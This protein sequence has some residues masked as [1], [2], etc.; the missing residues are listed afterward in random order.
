LDKGHYV[1]RYIYNNE[2]I[3]IGRTIDIHRRISE[4]KNEEKFQEFCIENDI[5]Y[6]DLLVEYISLSNSTEESIVEK[7]LINH[8]KPL[9]NSSDNHKSISEYI[10]FSIDNKWEKYEYHPFTK[11]KVPLII[12]SIT[13][14][15]KFERM[16]CDWNN[17]NELVKILNN[18][19]LDDNRD[20]IMVSSINCLLLYLRYKSSV[21]CKSFAKYSIKKKNGNVKLDRKIC[22]MVKFTPLF[23]LSMNQIRDNILRYTGY[24][25]SFSGEKTYESLFLNNQLEKLFPEMKCEI[26]VGEDKF[27][28]LI[29]EL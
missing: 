21:T 6:K 15:N 13:S 4:H 20:E 28:E 18:I 5:E 26:N 29:K 16:I 3:Y 1:Y 25:N 17:I 7:M 22:E 2:I 10:H 11:Q 27:F 8:Y 14:E 9:L 12:T 19:D 24:S 23:K